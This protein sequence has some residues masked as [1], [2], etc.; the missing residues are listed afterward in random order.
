MAFAAE[1]HLAEGQFRHLKTTL[2]KLG[3]R[4]FDLARVGQR[5]LKG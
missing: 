2:N 5:F 4:N 1:V 3:S